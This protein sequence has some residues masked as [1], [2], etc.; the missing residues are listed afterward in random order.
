[1]VHASESP[2]LKNIGEPCMGEPYARFDEGGL[3]SGFGHRVWLLRHSTPKGRATSWSKT[4]AVLEVQQTCPLLY[5]P[6]G[7]RV[8]SGLRLLSAAGRER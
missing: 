1:M 6:A 8:P 5:R 3:G 7:A 2:R 4:P